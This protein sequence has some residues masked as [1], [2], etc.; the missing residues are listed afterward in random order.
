VH[1]KGTPT[2]KGRQRDT[3]AKGTPTD[4]ALKRDEKNRVDASIDILADDVRVKEDGIDIVI[5][6][7]QRTA[8]Q[9][10]N[11]LQLETEKNVRG[12]SESDAFKLLI[13]VLL[14]H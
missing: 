12:D 4:I 10:C 5:L 8:T 9:S 6:G 13:L 1:A 3:N 7:Q 2:P 14:P 11:I